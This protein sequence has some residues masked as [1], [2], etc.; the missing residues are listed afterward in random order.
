M[1]SFIMTRCKNLRFLG[2]FVVVP[3]GLGLL[4]VSLMNRTRPV[5]ANEI[6]LDSPPAAPIDGERAYKYLKQICEIGPRTAG[7]AANTRQREMVKDHF[8]KMGAAVHEQPFRAVHPQ[9][10]EQLVMVNLVAAWHPERLERVVIAAHYDTRPHPDQETTPERRALPF[11]GANDCASGVALLMEMAHHLND[12]ET[13]WGVDLVL[14]D[15]EELVYGNDPRERQGEYF[16]GSMEFARIYR[17][18]VE[19]RRTRM[20]YSAG[21]VLDMI[22]G[23]NLRLNQEP[24]SR[25]ALPSW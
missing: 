21:I 16:L 13:Q 7:S 12:L 9:T 19:L 15:G 14:F 1:R 24:N 25:E 8:K 5:E 6:M 10:G 11:L 2:T 4:A 20:R 23:R 3:V 17:E 18:Q 22:G